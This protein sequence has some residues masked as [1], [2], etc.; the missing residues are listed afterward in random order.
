MSAP[1]HPTD[2]KSASLLQPAGEEAPPVYSEASSDSPIVIGDGNV[3]SD[4]PRP[5]A[6]NYGPGNRQSY[7]PRAERKGTWNFGLFDCFSDPGATAKACCCPC[8]S[9][10]QTRHRLHF[11]GTDAPIFSSP[12]LGYCLT[13][14]FIPGGEHIFGFL[15]RNELRQRLDIDQK[16][17]EASVRLPGRGGSLRADQ[18]NRPSPPMFESLHTAIGFLDD[19]WKHF[20]CPCCALVQEDRETRAW[21]REYEEGGLDSYDDAAAAGVEEEGERLLGSERSGLQGLRG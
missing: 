9:Y 15:Q 11:P 4:I 20:F 8:V 14:S 19:A 21:E 1:A 18:R 16:P 6:M 12:C 2:S 5:G 3:F 13:A 10:G 7:V 17:R